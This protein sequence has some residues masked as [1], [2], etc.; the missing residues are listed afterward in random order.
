MF[1]LPRAV[2]AAGLKV[3]SVDRLTRGIDAIEML[4]ASEQNNFRHN[5]APARPLPR[6]PL[7]WLLE[8]IEPRLWR[9]QVALWRRLYR[10]ERLYIDNVLV[11]ERPA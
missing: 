4:V 3:L 5:V 10:F 7:T 2:E 6:A 9:L 8:R 1:G 11:A